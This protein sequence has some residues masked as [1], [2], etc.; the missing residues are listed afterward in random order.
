MKESVDFK[1]LSIFDNFITSWGVFLSA[2]IYSEF[3]KPVRNIPVLLF[4]FTSLE[5]FKNS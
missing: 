5:L 3:K 4:I 1:G 2:K